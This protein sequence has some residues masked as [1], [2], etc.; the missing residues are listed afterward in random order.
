MVFISSSIG[1]LEIN[2][3]SRKVSSR[4]P[5][6]YQSLTLRESSIE[7]EKSKKMAD[8]GVIGTLLLL[9]TAMTTYKGLRDTK[10]FEDYVFEVDA[11]LIHRE[12]KRLFSSGFLH[13]GWLHFGF[14]MIALLSFSWSLE[15]L[16]GYWKFLFIYFASMLGGSLLALFIHRNHGD[17]RAVGASGAISGVIFSSI[18]LFPEQQIEL[19]LIPIP[20]RGWVL[21][22]L[23]ILV[24]IFGIKSQR[25][26]IGH[27]AHLGGALTGAVI[28][29]FLMPFENIQWWVVALLLVPTIA[30]LVLIVRNPA[31]M[32]VQNYWG[33]TFEK[34]KRNFRAHSDPPGSEYREKDVYRPPAQKTRLEKQA[35]LD[36]LLEKIGRGGLNSLTQKERNRLAELRDEL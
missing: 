16:F 13:S 3:L 9:F 30:F 14:N 8:T 15:L 23:F 11:I 12:W 36:D 31:V 5:F 35:E 29:L 17:Y 19:I 18:L 22:A 1:Q 26:N 33:E 6:V 4:F 20:F 21:G 25:G 27:E 32:M 2:I 24:S 34:W 28:T 10:F 7:F